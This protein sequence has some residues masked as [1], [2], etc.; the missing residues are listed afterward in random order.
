MDHTSPMTPSNPAADEMITLPK[1]EIDKLREDAQQNLDG[2]KRAKADF[3]N[4][5]KET[6]QFRGELIKFSSQTAIATFIPLYN[7]L[8]TAC[9]HLTDELKAH[10][11]IEG[12]KKIKQE[13]EKV[14]KEQGIEMID[15]EGKVFDPTMHEAINSEPNAALAD[16]T[17]SRIAQNGYTMHGKMLIPAKVIIVKNT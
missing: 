13:F 16:D 4:L 5:K 17:V 3:I 2:W 14:L 7:H 9:T 8:V 11:W 1:N 10:P 12:I 15:A 6:E